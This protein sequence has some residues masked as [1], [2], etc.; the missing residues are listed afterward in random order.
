MKYLA[1]LEHKSRGSIGFP[2]EYH[3]LNREHP[4]YEMP[5]HWHNEFELIWVLSGEFDLVVNEKTFKLKQGD[6]AL[7]SSGAVH[8]GFCFDCV[9][10][11]IVFDYE[12]ICQ[13]NFTELSK[14]LEYL[15]NMENQVKLIENGNDLSKISE[16]I[17]DLFRKGHLKSSKRLQALGCCFEL[18][19]EIIDNFP[20]NEAATAQDKNINRMKDILTYIRQYYGEN[21]SLEDLSKKADLNPKYLCQLFKKLTGKTPIDY[22]IYYRVECA[23]EQLIFTENSITEIALSC[24]FN[25]ISYFIKKFS[26]LKDLTP[27]KYRERNR[28]NDRS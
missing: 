12:A 9:Y 10:E 22:L 20:I 11:C 17:F 24:G 16:K 14:T 23:C 15:D 28:V 27:L 8:A 13:K 7:I 3:Y 21:I 6:S 19:G 18:L 26:Q 2:F 1:N 5:F 4:R 25:D